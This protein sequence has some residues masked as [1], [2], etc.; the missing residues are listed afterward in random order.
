MTFQIKELMDMT[1]EIDCGKNWLL[2]MV[3]ST[4]FPYYHVHVLWHLASDSHYSFLGCCWVEYCQPR[5]ERYPT[6]RKV[7]ELATQMHQ[8]L[9]ALKYCVRMRLHVTL[10][11][12]FQSTSYHVKNFS[13]LN[14]EALRLQRISKSNW[15]NFTENLLKAQEAK[16]V[17]NRKLGA[18]STEVFVYFFCK[19]I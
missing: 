16:Q 12:D 8:Y 2:P 10:L 5:G 15:G 6:K 14:D 7:S 17:K 1:N 13:S 3:W 18:P 9:S 4:P 19:N 11:L